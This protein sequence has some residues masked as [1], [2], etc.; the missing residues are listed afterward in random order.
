V[1]RPGAA[2]L[3]SSGVIVVTAAVGYM[4]GSRLI[5]AYAPKAIASFGSGRERIS[6]RVIYPPGTAVDSSPLSKE[7][8]NT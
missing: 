5:T 7:H 8:R 6:I 2:D 3:P 1:L 4:V